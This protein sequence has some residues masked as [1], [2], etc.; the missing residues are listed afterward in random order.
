M[1]V[2]TYQ[3]FIGVLVGGLL[4]VTA[5]QADPFAG[6]DTEPAQGPQA[7]VWGDPEESGPASSG[8]TW[9]G[10]GYESRMGDSTDP[11][12]AAASTGGSG[13]GQGGGQGQGRR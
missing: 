2:V 10:M 11:A 3:P 4:S 5:V 12:D 13:G 9:F 8:W 7:E 1:Q 6:T